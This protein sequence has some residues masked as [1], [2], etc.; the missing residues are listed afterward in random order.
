ME[1]PHHLFAYAACPAYSSKGLEILYQG[2]YPGPPVD[3]VVLKKTLV[4]RGKN[5][6]LQQAGDF[7]QRQPVVNIPW[8]IK[9]HRQ[10]NAVTIKE[11]RP[12]KGQALRAKISR[13]REQPGKGCDDE[14]GQGRE[15]E[16]EGG[17]ESLPR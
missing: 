4:L 7:M 12:V 3:T 6:V 11:L 10:G 15:A 16:E 13:K 14:Q 8:V 2:M 1:D 17:A 5:S 9:G